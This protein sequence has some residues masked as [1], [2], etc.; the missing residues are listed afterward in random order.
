MSSCCPKCFDWLEGKTELQAHV[1]TLNQSKGYN[2]RPDLYPFVTL[3][4]QNGSGFASKIFA[5]H[6]I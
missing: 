6:A 4:L 1:Y 2:W 3:T 5:L